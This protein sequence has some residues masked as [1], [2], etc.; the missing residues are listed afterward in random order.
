[1]AAENLQHLADAEAR[2]SSKLNQLSNM[3]NSINT[4]SAVNNTYI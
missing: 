4:N 2:A 3:L 1:M